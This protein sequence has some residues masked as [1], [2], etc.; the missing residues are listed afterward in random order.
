MTSIGFD[1]NW[2]SL[3]LW[4]RKRDSLKLW[5]RKREGFIKKRSGNDCSLAQPHTEVQGR[6]R[7]STGLPR[8]AKREG[9]N[10]IQAVYVEKLISTFLWWGG[11]GYLLDICSWKLEAKKGNRK[12]WVSGQ[13]WCQG[14]LRWGNL[15]APILSHSLP[16]IANIKLSKNRT[17]FLHSAKFVAYY[18]CGGTV[19]AVATLM[20]DP[21][22]AD[23]ANMTQEGKTL[24]KEEARDPEE[25]W[26]AKYS[27]QAK[28]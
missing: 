12:K 25:A 7:F 26:R 15:H 3:E 23:F 10:L 20:R 13:T 28:A 24:T 1:F 16:Y 19:A 9:I 6:S 8:I 27:I 21:V 5:Q 2:D 18:I 11:Q 22:A 14:N 17:Y 4:H